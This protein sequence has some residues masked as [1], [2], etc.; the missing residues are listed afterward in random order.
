MTSGTRVLLHDPTDLPALEPN[1]LLA[2]GVTTVQGYSSLPSQRY[3]EL[4]AATSS[5]PSLF[6]LWGAP[7]VV[8]EPANP[9]D[10]H[11]VD[12]VRFRAQHPLA[13]G[14]WR[15]RGD[16]VHGP[17]QTWVRSPACG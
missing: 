15:R 9:A 14:L 5:Q 12:G 6:D 2:D 1:Q 8:V 17:R 7:L 16:H 3:V 4:E 10:L 11:E 13:A